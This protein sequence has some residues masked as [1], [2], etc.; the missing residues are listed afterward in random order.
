MDKAKYNADL[1]AILRQLKDKG[2]QMEV[3]K[4]LNGL[5]NL[6]RIPGHEILD[7]VK[8]FVQVKQEDPKFPFKDYMERAQLGS[9]QTMANIMA[10]PGPKAA[11]SA[12]KDNFTMSK[13]DIKSLSIQLGFPQMLPPLDE[14]VQPEVPEDIK[15]AK[16][17]SVPPPEMPVK[18]PLATGTV[19]KHLT[20]QFRYAQTSSKDMGGGMG[21]VIPYQDKALDREVIRKKPKTKDEEGN[22]LSINELSDDLAV[23]EREMRISGSLVYANIP[24]VYE[25]GIDKRDGVPYFDMLKIIGKPL[26]DIIEAVQKD[27]RKKTDAKEY[28]LQRRVQIFADICRAMAYAHSKKII[29]RDLKPGNVMIGDKDR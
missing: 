18:N 25:A 15:H 27:R 29:H 28:T 2:D 16:T 5:Q 9:K 7:Y 19:T 12:P 26:N 4:V 23:V 20:S 1:V 10:K 14:I 24:P 6:D 8:G 13:A 17:I 21:S 3:I 11:K 22:S